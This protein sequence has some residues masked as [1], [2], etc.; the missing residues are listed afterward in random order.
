VFN[1]RTAWATAPQFYFPGWRVVVDGVDVPD[2]ELRRNVP[3]AGL[4][5]FRLEKGRHDILAYYDG[6]PGWRLQT[7]LVVAS[8]LGFVAFCV[9][10]GKLSEGRDRPEHGP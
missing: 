4:I 2:S 10:A 3:P 5:R 1:D 9:E 7:T 6:P 8:F